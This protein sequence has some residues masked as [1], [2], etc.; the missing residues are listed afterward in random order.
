MAKVSKRESDSMA[1][2]VVVAIDLHRGHL[3]PAVA[4]MPLPVELSTKVVSA[5]KEFFDQCRIDGVPVIHLL[6]QYRDESEILS[7]PAWRARAG[8]PSA[9]RSN[10]ARHNLSGMPGVAVMPEL[11]HSNDVLID[12]KKRYDCFVGTDLDFVLKSM[13]VMSLWIVGVN[14]NSCVLATAIAA[15]CRDYDVTI[16]SDCVETMDGEDFHYSAM[17][18]FERAFGKVTCAKDLIGQHR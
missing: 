11:F 13:G 15:S 17:K 18:I 4:T 3:D 8:D 5:S 2:T 7:N 12:S 1:K 10:V 6:T 16:V 14:T 9:T